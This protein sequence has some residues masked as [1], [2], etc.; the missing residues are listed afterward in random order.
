MKRGAFSRSSKGLSPLIATVLLIAFAVALGVMV[1]NWGKSASATRA[2]ET[3]TC[4]MVKFDPCS[5]DSQ[6]LLCVNPV[7]YS[8]VNEPM[9][10]KVCTG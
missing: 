1:M 9:E 8:L 2:G 3:P 10:Y 7:P 5:V 6:S 4:Q